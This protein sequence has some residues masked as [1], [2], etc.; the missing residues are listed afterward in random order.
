M[1]RM[2]YFH[3]TIKRLVKG[4]LAL[5]LFSTI[6][7]IPTFADWRDESGYLELAD[8]LDRPE[9]GYCFDIAGAGDWVNFNMPLNAHNCKLP[10]LF[11]DGA[12]IFKNPGPIRFPA[13]QRCVTAVGLNGRSLPGAAL[14]AKPCAEDIDENS[15]PFVSMSLQ[16]FRHLDDGRIELENSNL[17]IAV[18]AVSDR[19]FSPDHR[20]RALFLVD[21]NTIDA[22]RSV[23]KLF[24]IQS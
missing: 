2:G 3:S 11:P 4:A 19:T 6:I 10:G 17:C 18:G 12:V 14:M 8:R 5:S 23:W 1:N 7:Q 13:Y 16:R 22:D 15:S 21:C 24:Q 9:D 20:W